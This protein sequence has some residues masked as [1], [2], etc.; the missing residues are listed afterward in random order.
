MKSLWRIISPQIR[1]AG[2]W[3]L[4]GVPPSLALT[5]FVISPDVIRT[6]TTDPLG[7]RMIVAG[8]V[9]QVIG[10]LIIRRLVRID[11]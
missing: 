4:A 8:V 2:G 1:R 11:Y 7:V 5:I 3:V 10:T 6:L 9:L